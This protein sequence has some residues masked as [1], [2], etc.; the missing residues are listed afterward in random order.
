M[1]LLQEIREIVE[2]V[3]LAT[4]CLRNV[5]IRNICMVYQKKKMEG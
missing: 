5:L 4:E 3:T 1:S 2:F